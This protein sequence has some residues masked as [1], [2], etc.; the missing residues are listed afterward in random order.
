LEPASPSVARSALY[1]GTVKRGNMVR[2]VRGAGTLKPEDIRSISTTATGRV[3]RY[4]QAGTPVKPDTVIVELSNPDLRQQVNDAE[5][6]WK[7]AGAQLD[8]A[9][10]NQ[11][12][13]RIQQENAV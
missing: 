12:I 5:L 1:F 9:K 7:A 10:A 8:N 3:E 11:K 6:A 4:L 2:E 13:Q